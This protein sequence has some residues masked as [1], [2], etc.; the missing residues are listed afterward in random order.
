MCR[1][2]FGS[3]ISKLKFDIIL[4]I[5]SSSLITSYQN[6]PIRLNLHSSQNSLHQICYVNTK[7]YRENNQEWEIQLFLGRGLSVNKVFPD[8]HFHLSQVKL[9]GGDLSELV[10]LKLSGIMLRFASTPGPANHAACGF[11]SKLLPTLFWQQNV[12]LNKLCTC[13]GGGGAPRAFIWFQ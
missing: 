7:V 12:L 4:F 5:C 13:L 3:S 6:N 11:C 9:G 8:D 10:I 1:K 2:L